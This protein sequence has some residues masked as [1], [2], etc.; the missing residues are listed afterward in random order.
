M[1]S[2]GKY[3]GVRRVIKIANSSGVTLDKRLT[4]SMKIKPGDYLEISFNKLTN[5]K[6]KGRK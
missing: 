5:K 3:T 2:M 6:K 4:D 1:N